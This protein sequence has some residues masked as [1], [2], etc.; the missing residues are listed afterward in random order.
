MGRALAA[1]GIAQM[2]GLWIL[3]AAGLKYEKVISETTFEVLLPLFFAFTLVSFLL[4]Q[5][6]KLKV[7]GLE[8]DLE[9]TTLEPL[10]GTKGLKLETSG[11]LTPSSNITPESGKLV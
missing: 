9:K 1:L 4:P 11:T 6:T 10:E 7:G 3:Y 5:L 2:V 8:A